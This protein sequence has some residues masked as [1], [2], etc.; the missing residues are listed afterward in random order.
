M[1]D[2]NV[3]SPVRAVD[4]TI[5]EGVIQLSEK[6]AAELISIGAVELA[7]DATPS[8]PEVRHAKICEAIGLLDPSNAELWLGNGKPDLA[9]FVALTGWSITAKERD[10]AWAD[11]KPAV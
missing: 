11:V 5:K 9:A 3:L 4:G 8:D 2:Y 7:V 6:D 1:K 10:M